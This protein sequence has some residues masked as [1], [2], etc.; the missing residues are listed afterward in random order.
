M[1]KRTLIFVLLV[2]AAFFGINFFFDR[3]RDD[4]NRQE[5]QLREAKKAKEQVM[6][7][8]EVSKRTAQAADLPLLEIYSDE[9]GQN[10][11]SMG[12]DVEGSLLTLGWENQP[13][14]VYVKKE[15]QFAKMTLMTPNSVVSG[16][17]FYASSESANL[18]TASVPEIGSYDLQLVAFAPHSNDVTVKLGLYTDGSLNIVSGPLSQ[19]AIALYKTAQGYLPLGFYESLGNVFVD[20]QDVPVLSNIAAN[21]ALQFSAPIT[22]ENKAE[23][24]FVLE[25]EYQQLVFSNVGGS[26]VEINL[27][28]ENEANQAS[29]VKEIG[30]DRQI[31]KDYS[32]NA[33]F[34]SHPYFT[35]STEKNGQWI[36]HKA[37]TIGGYYP[38]IRR[39]INAG[40]HLKGFNLSPQYYALNVVSEYPEMAQLVY[41]VKQFDRNHIVFEAMQPHRKITKTYTLADQNQGGAPYTFQVAVKIEGDSRGLWLTSGVPEVELMSG[42]STPQIQYRITRQ[43]KSEV[44]KLDL[45]KVKEIITV[46]SVYPDWVANSNGYLGLII[47]P[48]DEISSGYRA[49][50]VAGTAVPT[51]LSVIDPQH[52][53][54]KAADY[55]GYQ[56]YLPFPNKGGTFNFR[57]FAGPFEEKTLKAVDL[58]YSDPATGY[59]PDYIACKTFYGWF[60][61]I[62]EPFAKFLF[63]VMKFFYSVTHSW[64]FS[65]I[66]LT[67]FLR[68]LLYPLN[69][70]SIKSM[71]RMQLI[72][73]QVQAIQAKYKKDPKKAQVE[74]MNLYREKKVNPFTGCIPILIQMPFL[75]GMFDLLKSSFQLR[76]ASFIPG[77]ID[78]LT[79]PDVLFEWS[80]PI[81]FIGTQ[82]HLLPFLLG[83]VMYL[84]QRFS[85]TMPKDQSLWTDQQRQQRA[86]G[87]IMTLVFTVMFYH[88]PSGLN[89]Y[90]LSSMLLGILQQWI[91]NKMMTKE[92]AELQ[93]PSSSGKKKLEIKKT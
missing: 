39:D 86:M 82:F 92:N 6:Q 53:P 68:L 80:T 25:N 52:Q 33:H 59:N 45:P 13:K 85:S 10:F 38:L 87:N 14:T 72:S 19:N 54:H 23:K 76:G 8:A 3:Q 40:N 83:A 88:F 36:E 42:S 63:I 34:P 70:W 44:E 84:Q 91:T 74:I 21:D 30:F 16:P 64:A 93:S 4:R 50:G 11:V 65:I 9:M 78:N 81:F 66:L 49:T 37:G 57:V 5:L 75:I 20:I 67:V 43:A 41:E 26:L 27:P 55:P 1:D 24:Y 77:W 62:S 22:P 71:R 79:A 69:A 31:A 47:D 46:S 61:F 58:A 51:R 90:W 35:P 17:V 29:A 2:A 60:S 73:P 28:F 56:I 7:Q 15:G 32:F 48:I 89:L 12:I 18:H